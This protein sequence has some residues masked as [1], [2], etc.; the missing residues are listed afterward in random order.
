MILKEF[1]Q[2]IYN[3][4]TDYNYPSQVM[5]QSNLLETVSSDIY[6]DPKRF[7]YELLQN[8]DDSSIRNSKN[9]VSIKIINDYLV[10]AHNG[11]IFSNRD[12]EGLCSVSNGTKKDD[13]TKTGYKGI[14]FKSVF[15]QSEEVTIYTNNEYFRFDKKHK[16]KWKTKWGNTQE[17]W[18]KENKRLFISPWQLIPIYTEKDFLSHEINIFL[19]E[20][21]FT[22]A[23]ILKIKSIDNLKKE[24]NDLIQ[25]INM[26]IFLRNI[27][28]INILIDEETIIEI[29]HISD[30]EIILKKNSI[31]KSSWLIKNIKLEVDSEIKQEIQFEKN[32]PDKLK[33]SD[34]IE[35]TLCAKKDKQGIVKV[36]ENE[37]LLYSYLPTSTR[38]NLPILVNATFIMGANRE[39]L[40]TDSLWNKWLFSNISHK[41]IEWISELVLTEYSF[42]AYRLFP[43]KLNSNYSFNFD[44]NNGIDKAI[45]TVPLLLSIEQKLLKIK[46]SIYDEVSFSNQHFISQSLVKDFVLEKKN[47]EK[48]IDYNPFIQKTSYEHIFHEI[49]LMEFKWEDISSFLNYRDFVEIHNVSDNIELI[50]FLKESERPGRIKDKTFKNWSFIMDHQEQL[51]MPIDILLPLVD[52]EDWEK[53][54][55]LSYLHNDLKDFISLNGEYKKWLEELGIKEKT[56]ISYIET[57]ILPH[58]EDY[59]TTNSA[60][61]QT[62][63]FYE[64]FIQEKLTED[65]FNKLSNMKVLTTKGNKIPI[66]DCYFSNC[67]NPEVELETLLDRDIFLNENYLFTNED[68]DIIKVFFNKLGV[69]Q[70]I[71]SIKPEER[72]TK[73]VLNNKYEINKEYFNNIDQYTGY[74]HLP[75]TSYSDIMSIEY[76]LCTVDYNLSKLYWNYIVTSDY[77]AEIN[78]KAI[79]YWGY[80]TQNGQVHGKSIENYISWLVRNI[81]CIPTKLKKCFKSTEVFLNNDSISKIGD[82]YLPIVDIENLDDPWK[83]FFNFKTF[84]EFDDYIEAFSLIMKDVP[85]DKKLKKDNLDKVMNIYEYFIDSCLN[86]DES[87]IK[88]IKDTF[89]SLLIPDSNLNVRLLNELKYT[90]EEDTSIFSDDYKFMYFNK[91]NQS[92]PNLKSFL[93]IIEI[94]VLTDKDFQIEKIGEKRESSLK[95]E[96][97]TI[98]PYLNNWLFHQNNLFDVEKQDVLRIQIEEI[99]IFEFERLETPNKSIKIYFEDHILNIAKTWKSNSVQI[100]LFTKLSNYLNIKGHEDK[101]RFLLNA[102]DKDEI[103]EY[104]TSEKIELPTVI[105]PDKSHEAISQEEEIATLGITKKDYADITKIA[106]NYSHESESSIEKKKYILKLLKRSKKNVLEHLNSLDEYNCENV[107][108]SALTVLSGIKK[109]G[110]DIFIIPRP[111]D[112]GQVILHYD[113]EF[114]TLE[115]ADSE[116]WYE[117]EDSA[118]KKL[119]FGKVLREAKIN[120]IPIIKT[121]KNITDIIYDYGNEDIIYK[122][123]LPS[124]FDIAKIMASLANTNGGYLIIGCSKEEG[125]IGLS[126]EFNIDELT[127]KSIEYSSYFEQF[128]I[129]EKIIDGKT[130][131]VIKIDKSDETIFIEGKKYIRYGSIIIEELTNNDKPLIITEGKTDWKHIKK[132]LERFK[133]NGSYL[134]LDIQFL[135]YEEMNMGDGELDRMVQTYCKTEQSKKHIFIFDR[136]NS[137]FLKKYA[138][139]R[140]NNHGNNVYSFCIPKISD[141]LDRICIEFYYKEEDLTTEDENGRKI[142]IG[143]DFLS[144][145]NSLCG[146]YITEKRKANKLDILDRDKKVYLREDIEWENNIALSKNDFTNNIINEVEN[147]DSFD[148]DYFKLIFDVT[149]DIINN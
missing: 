84:L 9:Q 3:E 30:C 35:L 133:N 105:I 85:S 61:K 26:F 92:H 33:E 11:K 131:I 125:I 121:N 147:F 132:A 70:N 146:K 8:A 135:E 56:E 47:K 107:D 142:F 21:N 68:R 15:G 71:L 128:K 101:L 118:P 6:T 93:E 37:S 12:I 13:K 75:I 141:E 46:D 91:E 72:I 50:K 43:Q 52:D 129:E 34:Q 22:V 67:F 59:I 69:K 77:F 140:F 63:D 64:L 108:T 134:D 145:G 88:L 138:K 29:E 100:E 17:E 66:S 109:N 16:I 4:K 116:L 49:G 78:K 31:I 73:L 87:K 126:S 117:D 24:L 96:L 25:N 42:Q 90:N 106:N 149:M 137:T 53:E 136:D 54:T 55:E 57:N 144:N 39:S 110:N 82:G 2:K 98:L 19:E 95:K 120:R 123:I 103:I 58:I 1:I 32:I 60:I 10:F 51:K 48:N 111:S 97:L 130:L 5:D 40:H 79:G 36:I 143:K 44:Y 122:P 148:I 94:E 18:E 102:D 41:L 14:G 81:D 115:Y 104:F 38:I 45:E 7:I 86:W 76:I 112:D 27:N 20:K 89:N 127:R 62:K 119:T 74:S 80:S 65:I 83:S 113:S 99:E 139:E 28:Q 114:A 23:T 124:S